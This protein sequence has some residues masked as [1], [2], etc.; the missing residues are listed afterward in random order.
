M[1]WASASAADDGHLDLLDDGER[2]RRE[3]FRHDADRARM[4]VGVALA[5]TAVAGLLGTA[6]GDLVFDRGCLRCGQPHGKPR[7]AGPGADLHFS[8]SHS[9]DRVCVAVTRRAPVGVDVES[10]APA[11]EPERLAAAA[12]TP[13]EFAR[14]L[15][16]PQERR[17]I[18][19]IRAWTRKES[20]LKATGDGLALPM[21]RIGLADGDG[22]GPVLD[23]WAADVPRPAARLY[24]LHP[25]PG[26][27][28]CVT[29]L[30]DRPCRI[31]ERDGEELLRRMP[32]RH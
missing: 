23:H 16:L 1:W 14:W 32:D 5:K 27:L 3:R 20:L 22:D 26:Y 29:V 11:P 2:R 12:L 9:G 18:E 28:A 21:G 6:P 8:V 31:D 13:A 15:Q 24:D 17:R 10:L 7:L 25:G 4:L 19:L 30:S